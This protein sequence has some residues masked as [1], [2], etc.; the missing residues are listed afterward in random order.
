MQCGYDPELLNKLIHVVGN[1]DRN[2]LIEYKPKR[3]NNKCF[4][5]STFNFG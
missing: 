3:E 4:D 2:Q 5:N 1:I